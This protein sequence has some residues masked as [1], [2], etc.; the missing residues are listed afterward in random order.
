MLNPRTSGHLR[1]IEILYYLLEDAPPDPVTGRC[2]HGSLQTVR[3]VD[4]MGDRSTFYDYRNDGVSDVSFDSCT[5]DNQGNIQ[6][7]FASELGVYIVADARVVYVLPRLAKL[8]NFNPDPPPEEPTLVI[9]RI[10]SGE[11]AIDISAASLYTGLYQGIWYGRLSITS[12]DRQQIDGRFN[13]SPASYRFGWFG[14]HNHSWLAERR[15]IDASLMHFGIYTWFPTY[16]PFGDPQPVNIW[17]PTPVYPRATRITWDMAPSV[18]G[19]LEI[20]TM[21]II[22]GM[23]AYF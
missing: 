2:I 18:I 8:V 17:V 3:Y 20:W 19:R 14:L 13:T 7:V 1:T 10:V 4:F 15:Q 23:D 16:E 5:I 12:F 6:Q 21:K 11:G 22:E 9:D